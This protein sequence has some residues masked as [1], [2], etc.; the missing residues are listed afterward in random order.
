MYK[1]KFFNIKFYYLKLNF[2][3][4]Q[5][6][7]EYIYILNTKATPLAQDVPKELPKEQSINYTTNNQTIK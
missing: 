6:K 5:A 3:F 2:F 4:E 1:R 7:M